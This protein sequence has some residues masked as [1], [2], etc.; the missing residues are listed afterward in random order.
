VEFVIENS[1][2]ADYQSLWPRMHTNEHESEIDLD[3]VAGSAIGAAYEVSNVPGAGFLE[4]VYE[5]ALAREL[6]LRRLRVSC[7]VSF[8]VS[9][10]GQL[11]G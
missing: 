8:P 9:Y 4:K 2:W 3:A 5:R 1:V 10:K 6:T 11:G 7:Q